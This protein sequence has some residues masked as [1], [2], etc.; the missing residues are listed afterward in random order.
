LSSGLRDGKEL[1]KTFE[2]AI[3]MLGKSEGVVFFLILHLIFGFQFRVSRR[4]KLAILGRNSLI[5]KLY[6]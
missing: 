4:F 3:I 5:V 1:G 2:T 6:S